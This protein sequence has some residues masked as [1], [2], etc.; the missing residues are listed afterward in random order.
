[1]LNLRMRMRLILPT[2][3][4]LILIAHGG[5]ATPQVT[6]QGLKTGYA[7]LA[8]HDY[9]QALTAADGILQSDPA[10]PG[11]AEAYYLRGRVFQE[12]AANVA[13]AGSDLQQARTA[14][15]NALALPKSDAVEGLIRAGLGDI[16]F[17]QDD[18][19]TAATQL[20]A[21][22]D[23]LQT[24]QEK[25]RDLYL[26]GVARQRLSQWVEADR[27][28]TQ[29][30]TQYPGSALAQQAQ[31]HLGA[32]QFFVDF[33]SSGAS[34]NDV[35]ASL[36]R[37]GLQAMPGSGGMI[38]VGPASSYEQARGLKERLAAVYHNATI[39]P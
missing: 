36:R 11:A 5:C 4:T 38:R 34:S 30:T 18:Y 23:K 7:A 22:S 33:A 17:K 16:A 10:G 13:A 2:M 35:I 37:Q 19:E 26:L 32:R 25:A 3:M 12:R 27:I 39:V 9:P 8:K 29:V 14:F 20:G 15:I 6:Q 21:A 28:F 31:A 1:M 24:P